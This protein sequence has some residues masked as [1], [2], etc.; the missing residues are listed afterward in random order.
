[1][2][3][4]RSC[5]TQNQSLIRIIEYVRENIRPYNISLF[6]QTIQRQ[7]TMQQTYLDREA[8]YSHSSGVAMDDEV[9]NAVVDKLLTNKD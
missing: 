5:L 3:L 9:D 1:M 6:D 7:Y 2:G 8:I 4:C